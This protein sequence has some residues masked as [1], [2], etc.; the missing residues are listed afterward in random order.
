MEWHKKIV[1][2]TPSWEAKA[3]SGA[4][5]EIVL[6]K[7]R[8]VVF[9]GSRPNVTYGRIGQKFES[10][11]DAKSFAEQYESESDKRYWYR[12]S[13]NPA[14]PPPTDAETVA[15][16]IASIVLIGLGV[17]LAYAAINPPGA[18]ESTST[19]LED[20]SALATLAALAP[21]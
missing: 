19:T 13:K 11:G 21:I 1:Y 7:G 16:G 9:R 4:V 14:T 8:Y 20:T 5:Y 3:P 2:G 18:P 10:L 12:S 15:G 6:Q 17:Y